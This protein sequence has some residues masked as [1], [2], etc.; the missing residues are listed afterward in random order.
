MGPFLNSEITPRPIRDCGSVIAKRD[1]AASF[2]SSCVGCSAPISTG[3]RGEDI[4]D[5]IAGDFD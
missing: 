5:M 4:E 2:V 3:I 1:Y